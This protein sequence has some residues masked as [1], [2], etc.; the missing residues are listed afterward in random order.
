MLSRIKGLRPGVIPTLHLI[1]EVI[2]VNVI[3]L[4][5]LWATHLSSRV[6]RAFDAHIDALVYGNAHHPADDHVDELVRVHR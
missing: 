2:D 5:F 6:R 3:A 1:A 4:R